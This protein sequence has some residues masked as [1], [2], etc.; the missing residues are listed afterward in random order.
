MQQTA[1][2]LKIITTGLQLLSF[3]EFKGP[4]S[5]IQAGENDYRSVDTA[6]N[7]VRAF[8]IWRKAVFLYSMC[9]WDLSALQNLNFRNMLIQT[10]SLLKF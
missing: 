3:V 2:S 6:F 1:Q 5:R 7:T 8:F 9:S 10:N 4:G